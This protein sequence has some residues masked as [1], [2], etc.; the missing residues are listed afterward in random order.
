MNVIYQYEEIIVSLHWQLPDSSNLS[1]YGKDQRTSLWVS[2][3][4]PQD[5]LAF[6]AHLRTV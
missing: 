5:T 3:R 2:L 4:A 1:I 6:Q